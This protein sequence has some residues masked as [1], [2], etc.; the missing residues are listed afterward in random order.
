MQ[1]NQNGFVGLPV[2]IAIVLGIVV[3]GGGAY[4]VTR[5]IP[6]QAP[7]VLDDIKTP[8]VSN[9][10]TASAGHSLAFEEAINKAD[11]NGVG[12]YFS[13][14]V[15]VLLEG[16]S[17]C[18]EV[19]ISRATQ[20]L[21][22][23]KGLTFTFNPNDAVVKNYIAYVSSQ[24]TNRRLMKDSPKL[25]FD[26]YI[27]GVESDVTQKNPAA[28]GYKFSNGKIT[29][30]FISPGRDEIDATANWKTYTNAQYGFELKYPTNMNIEATRDETILKL[31][32]PT[33][34]TADPA[35]DNSKQT[36][37]LISLVSSA[38]KNINANCPSS[39]NSN[40]II[41]SFHLVECKIF[42]NSNGV[43]YTRVVTQ[44]M[45]VAQDYK[46]QYVT[47]YILN[48]QKSSIFKVTWV[49]PS[50]NT[51]S[52]VTSDLDQIL[53][54]FKFTQSTKADNIV[55]PLGGS[56][57]KISCE[58]IDMPETCV[59]YSNASNPTLKEVC[60]SAMKCNTEGV[61]SARSD[62]YVT[63]GN[64][65]T[66]VLI[67]A[68][69]RLRYVHGIDSGTPGT[70]E[71]VKNWADFYPLIQPFTPH[72]GGMPFGATI[73]GDW[74]DAHTFKANWVKWSIG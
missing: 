40:S 7:A 18:G 35:S 49:D 34:Q 54:T 32:Y 42:K 3:L 69:T 20:E 28:I 56:T 58:L 38:T 66:K 4:L 39:E 61:N 46:N 51:L 45:S 1:K 31:V 29:D 14:N 26:E 9:N 6:T 17:C 36:R 62:F 25:Y 27:L 11:F 63:I 21:E 24:Y 47:A 23:I 60:S 5:P 8:A 65:K 41:D 37:F 48:E 71:E 50:V 12:K 52:Q 59:P 10:Q 57:L 44:G 67:D 33:T 55:P 70:V 73:Y 2:L 72:S 43:S 16:S 22:R 30:L 15:Y 53:S 19:N 68:E 13:N 64:S 74:I